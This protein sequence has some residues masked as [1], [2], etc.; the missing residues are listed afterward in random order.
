MSQRRAQA[1]L[2]L[3]DIRR[4]CETELATMKISRD[5]R[6]LLLSHGLGG[7]QARHY[8]FAERF[9]ELRA[10]VVRWAWRLRQLQ[11]EAA[12]TARDAQAKVVALVPRHSPR[13]CTQT[14]AVT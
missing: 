11:R 2:Q 4:T 8:D 7:V 5:V 1:P 12:R 14:Q 13:D 6:G 9:D 10:V 3:R